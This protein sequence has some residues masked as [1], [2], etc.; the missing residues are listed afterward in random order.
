MLTDVL[1][2]TVKSLTLDGQVCKSWVMATSLDCLCGRPEPRLCVSDQHLR[3]KRWQ[4]VTM[5]LMSSSGTACIW[6][7]DDSARSGSRSTDPCLQPV[8]WFQ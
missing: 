7:H 8:P 5:I 2:V 1:L 4:E 3:S 6:Q